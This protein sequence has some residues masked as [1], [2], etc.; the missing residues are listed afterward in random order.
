MEQSS[1]YSPS[2]SDDSYEGG[3]MSTYLLIKP[4]QDVV[5]ALSAAELLELGDIALG[6]TI[7]SLEWVG[8]STHLLL[9][10]VEAKSDRALKTFKR[11]AE[12]LL[13][14]KVIAEYPVVSSYRSTEPL[15]AG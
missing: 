8:L 7:T 3:S 5:I 2:R 4:N 15:S 13:H 12:E 11:H 10:L 6:V 14:A 9:C 1:M